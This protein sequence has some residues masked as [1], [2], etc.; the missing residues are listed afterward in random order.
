MNNIEKTKK[1][2]LISFDIF[3]TLICRCVN[4]PVDV[5][6]IVENQ[7]IK[8]HGKETAISNF[9]GVRIEA[10]RTA[11]Q[12]TLQEEISFDEIYSYIEVEKRILE[13]YMAIEEE[14][15]LDV[16]LPNPEMLSVYDECIRQGKRVIIT[17]DMYLPYKTIEQILHK[18]GYDGYSRLYLSSEIGKTKASGS[19]YKFIVDS[20]NI[21]PKNAIH[22]GDNIRSDIKNAR[23][24]GFHTCQIKKN[25]EKS[26]SNFEGEMLNR[27]IANT[28]QSKD[29][30]E[31][32]GYSALGPMLYG[33]IDWVRTNVADIK[34]EKLFFLSRDG[35]IM[36]QVYDIIK[37]DEDVFA[38]YMY[39]SRRALQV[40]A[41]HLNPEYKDVMTSMFLPRTVTVSWLIKKWGIKEADCTGEVNKLGL[42]MDMAFLGKEIVDNFSIQKLYDSL[43]DKVL[44]NSQA[45]YAAFL[46]YLESISFKGKVAIVDIGWYGNMQNALMKIIESSGL[47]VD[48]TGYYLGIVPDSGYQTKYKMNGY[49]FMKAQNENLFWRFKYLNSLMELFFMAPHGSARRYY[50]ENNTPMVELADFEFE[51]TDTFV[52]VKKVQNSAM[53]FI[54]KYDSSIAKYADNTVEI[55]L[56]NMMSTFMNPSL[57]VATAFGELSIWDEK[58]IKIARSVSVMDILGAPAKVKNIF[59]NVPWK[60]GFLKRLLKINLQY[61]KIV[62][63]LRALSR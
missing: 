6:R 49:L 59:V 38:Q 24:A 3:D 48:V 16:C 39:A 35:F 56:H 2:D 53:E 7:Y 11:R 20:E 12:K 10:E 57:T 50:I 29:V 52:A 5:F 54:I 31:T 25:V 1:F 34:A 4:K 21:N 62:L 46:N 36:K 63:K 22:F 26:I 37:T 18:N 8:R 9:A 28:N 51:G 55:Y 15:E 27:F 44:K 60:M 45:E 19:L 61:D 30:Y 58:W 13:E 42:T 47:N 33:F 23:M 40:A 32:V 17:S 14:V 41:I 43:K